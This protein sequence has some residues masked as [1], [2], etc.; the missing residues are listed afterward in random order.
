[1]AT[2]TKL[3]RSTGTVYKARIRHDG[4]A[5]LSKVFKNRS[6]AVKWAKAREVELDRDEAGLSSEGQRH[7]LA[8]AIERYRAEVLPELRPS[9]IR[10]YQYHLEYWASKFGHLRLPEV[11]AARIAEC[12]DELQGSG[13]SPA[14]VNR[15]LATLASVLTACV[16]RWHWLQLSPMRQVA[17]QTERNERTRFLSESE[18]QRL[19][20]ACKASE[21][22]DLYLAVLLSVTTGARQGEILGLHW[23][24]VDLRGGVLHLRVGNE[25]TTKG[26][27]R[28]VAIAAQVLPLLQKRK[29]EQQRGAVAKLRDNGLVFPS[30]VS[31][32]KPV[33]LRTPWE[34]AL[35]RAGIERFKWHDMRHSCASFLAMN[36]ASLREIGEVL[37]HR[38][39]ATTKRYAHLTEQ[40]THQLVRAVASKLL[41]GSDDE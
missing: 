36:G 24:D 41:Q 7:K 26:G 37:G 19:L 28:S 14:T 29:G 25:T 39:V 13:K 32:S 12:R 21:S 16:K 30:R 20:R 1:M 35:R 23:N 11:T 8:Q 15:Y 6:D 5:E 3:Q 31:Q 9:T 27:V 10:P 33:Q 34:T 22:P 40:H 17:K 18:L 2:I 38:S 4:Q